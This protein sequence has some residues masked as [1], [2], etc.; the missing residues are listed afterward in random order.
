MIY[1]EQGVVNQIVLTLTEVTTVPTPHYL[2]A[3][4]NEMNTLSVTQLFTTADT[5][6]W[7][8]RYN[9]F[10]LNEPVDIILNQGQFIYQ[11]YQSSTPYILPLTIA[12]STGVVILQ[13]TTRWGYQQAMWKQST[14][15]WGTQVEHHWLRRYP[16]HASSATSAPVN[17]DDLHL[18]F[19][20]KHSVRGDGAW[21]RHGREG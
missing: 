2:F 6:L 5:S 8:E 15:R 1:I 16:R 13:P 18:L 11:I 12:Q 9:L 7:P 21:D 10:V 17:G 14:L 19:V 3:F 4:T 20:Q